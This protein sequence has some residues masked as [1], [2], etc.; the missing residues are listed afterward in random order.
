L[1]EDL[2]LL[3]NHKINSEELRKIKLQNEVD[4]LENKLK[5]E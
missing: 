1:Y 4:N 5:T 2:F 3:E